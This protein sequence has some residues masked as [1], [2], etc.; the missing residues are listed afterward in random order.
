MRPRVV[1]PWETFKGRRTECEFRVLDRFQES[2]DGS[3][4][5]F[6]VLH[7]GHVA[8]GGDFDELSAGDGLGHRFHFRHR[9][10]LV[11]LTAEDERGNVD[12]REHLRAIGPIRKPAE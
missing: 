5:D 1:C 9:G 10:D 2:V 3:V 8:G 6:W 4:N 11:I 12:A 7:W